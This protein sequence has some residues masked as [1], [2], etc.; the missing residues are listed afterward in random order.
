M[1]PDDPGPDL[2]SDAPLKERRLDAVRVFLLLMID[3]VI[4]ADQR[5]V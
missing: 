3:D 4:V 5:N 1:A 2:F